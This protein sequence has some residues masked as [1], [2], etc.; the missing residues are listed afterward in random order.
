M[1]T[2]YNGF[3]LAQKDL[4]LRGPGE[5][6]GAR[7]SGKLNL[8]IASLFDIKL[9]EEVK[10]DINYIFDNFENFEFNKLLKT[11]EKNI[12]DIHLE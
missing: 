1:E 11:M 7:Q 4:E 8:K 6:Y 10:Q 12:R 3:K 9:I 2:V 5:V